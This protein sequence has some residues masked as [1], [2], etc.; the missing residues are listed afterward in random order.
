MLEK[1]ECG[2][3]T[4]RIMCPKCQGHQRVFGGNAIERCDYC[5]HTGM[6]YVAAV[7]PHPTIGPLQLVESDIPG[8]WQ[9]VGPWNVIV[10]HNGVELM[11]NNPAES[12]KN[13][14]LFQQARNLYDAL[15]EALKR[16]L[17][18]HA[19]GVLYDNIRYFLGQIDAPIC[20]EPKEEATTK[21]IQE[22]AA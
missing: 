9:L 14:R 15:Q 19:D 17:I 12:L 2:K 13:G 7:N 5:D 3:N 20:T 6:I 10:A 22:V 8:G 11:K 1:V 18:S 4:R 16:G 21:G